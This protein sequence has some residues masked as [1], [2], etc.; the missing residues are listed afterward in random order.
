MK[1]KRNWRCCLYGNMSKILLKM[2]LLT[3]LIFVSVA[4]VSANSY[5]QQTKFNM[6]LKNITVRQVFQEIEDKSEFILLYSEESVDVNRKVSVKVNN[7]TINSL[8]DQVFRGTNNYYEIHN[9]QIA[10]LSK[11]APALSFF[12]KI[13][14]S[15][16]QKTVSGKV[17]D[18]SGVPLPG[19]TVVVRGTTQGIITDVDGNY[20]LANVPSDATLVFSFVGMKAQEIAVAGKAS[21]NVT[22][23]EET[24]GIGE[25]VAIGYGTMKKS[26]LTGA[27]SQIKGET[28]KNLPVRSVADALQGK[29]AGVMISSTSG[30][31]G[32]AP[33]VRIRG[34]GTVN[35]NDPL[36][37]VDGLPQSSIGWLNTNEIESIDILKDA[38][39]TAIYGARAANGVILIT[40][41]RGKEKGD[42]FQSSIDFDAYFG[43]QNPIE[44]Y[45]MMNASEFMEYKNLAYT[46]AGYDAY[47]TSEEQEEILKFIKSNTGSEEG[48]NWWKEINNKNAPVQSYNI[49]FSGGMKDFSYRSSL[50]Y[51][52]Q[53][54]IIN[55]SDYER[56]SWRTNFD[57]NIK[58]WLKISGN[59][60]LVHEAKGNVLENSPGF[61]TAFIAFVCDPI[62]PVYRTNL[63]DIPSFLESS[64]FLD[65]IDPND[66]Y[67]WYSPILFSNKQNPVAQTDIY[68]D[69]KWKGL[70]VKGGLA[71]EINFLKSLKFK[72]NFGV[73]LSRGNSDGFTPEYYLDGDQYSDNAVVKKTEESTDYWIWE[74]TLTFD[75]TMGDHHVL[76]MVGASA[77]ESRYEQVYASKEGLASN[78]EDQ[79]IL[80]AAS[81]N[82][83]AT[84]Y[85][86]ERALASFFGRAF[87][88][89]KNKYMFT[90]NVR[91]DGS[92]NFGSGHKWGLFP[93]FSLGW[94]FTSEDFMQ[95]LLSFLSNGK[96]RFSWGEIG[97]Q[98][99]DAG[100]YQT[101]YSGNLG[102]YLFGTGYSAQLRGGINS[103]GNSAVKWETT[104]QTDIGL[105]LKFLDG[106]LNFVG[107]WFRKKT[108]GML[109]EVSLPSY[110]GY[111]NNPYSN[112]GSV[113]NT[114][115][116][117]DIRYR[118]SFRDLNYNIGF[119]IFTFKNEV[120]SL[121]GGEPLYG[122]TWISYNT[123]KTEVGK[124]I[125]YFYGY[126]T[127]GI[128]Q[129]QDEVD[130]YFQDDAVPGDLR[131]V[132]VNGDKEIDSDD[133]TEIGSPFPDFS[134]GLNLSGE[135]KGF[136][137]QLL[138]QGT[139]GNEIMNIKKIDMNSGV[140]WYNAPKDLMDKAWSS[141][142]PGNSQFRISAVNDNNLRVS[143]WL[144]EDGSYLR[145][146]NIQVGYSL[147]QDML[148]RINIQK[149]RFWIGAYNLFTITGYSG[150]DPEIGNSSPLSS[151]VDD[152]YYP[153]SASYMIGVNAT[154]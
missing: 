74:N 7:E 151:G 94:V 104:R 27:V 16:Q 126:K 57:H 64:L 92:S 110:L 135:Y 31:P 49:S 35:D 119:N 89:Y 140:G 69:N 139:I 71:A 78:D 82:A 17:T 5:S 59:I 112:A 32:S 105:E 53:D 153:Q 19:V 116:E 85:K 84:G 13:T 97:N 45:D 144:V 43:I 33:A 22:M 25:V 63:K 108:E 80:N 75:K 12:D 66:R 147:H 137:I 39:A 56:I 106:K 152:A 26:D 77:E 44:V 107:D 124:S 73:D 103:M 48:T 142:N 79:W 109:L 117:F 146:K 86:S 76:A 123:T 128:F 96:L 129:S 67:S 41:Y 102:Y 28:L 141:T 23:E 58:S 133:R 1:K 30:S 150:L 8:L 70:Q 81:E 21:I 120:T 60:G 122:G 15:V 93:S 72:T 50:G 38:S 6:N 101:T 138:F 132:D 88:S 149:V 131:Y 24:I 37:V 99:I 83:A 47:F 3:F 55:G 115:W 134:Y 11:E 125:G 136:D 51:M 154:F 100:A 54:G 130:S 61:N 91:Y 87:Y 42:K 121:G 95:N 90:G 40:T 111:T 148:K 10:I 29:T 98:S 127:D 68:E 118:D 114:G 20:M 143:D 36:Y 62:S 145:L 34:V 52:N 14:G 2:R 113:K 65:E 46:N 18:S 9:R 4:S